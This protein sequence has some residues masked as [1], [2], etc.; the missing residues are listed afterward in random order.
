MRLGI[1]FLRAWRIQRKA[2]EWNLELLAG[3][4]PE[5]RAEFETWLAADPEHAREYRIFDTFSE[6]S[7]GLARPERQHRRNPLFRPAYA[8]A[9][10][11]VVVI[12]A[13]L[14]ITDRGT[15]V[16]Y[17]AVTNDRRAIRLVQL[18]D[19]S[20]IALDTNTSLSVTFTPELREVE[21]H[22]GRAR[23]QV[24]PDPK[25]PFVVRSKHS[26][27]AASG[28]AFDVDIG[29]SADFII[30]RRGGVSVATQDDQTGAQNL[31]SGETVRVGDGKITP[32]SIGREERL[33]A[34]GRLWFDQS[35]LSDIVA[36]ANRVGGPPIHVAD[37]DIGAMKVTAVLDLRDTHALAQKLAAA[38]DLHVQETSDGIVL[39]R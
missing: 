12:A 38:F 3:T 26:R 4:T 37:P 27:I 20:R 32:A 22:S 11:C 13:A 2:A 35:P 16:A 17:A 1:P 28:G 29:E 7:P 31:A 6:L 10:A 14:L 5:R 15:G 34:V 8:F 30:S 23:F 18:S 9:A 24:A 33:W 21:L 25:R 19:G 36:M 39:M